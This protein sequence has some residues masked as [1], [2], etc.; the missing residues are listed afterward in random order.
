MVNRATES[1]GST[2]FPQNRQIFTFIVAIAHSCTINII[3][4]HAIVL[5]QRVRGCAAEHVAFRVLLHAS[6]SCMN[7]LGPYVY[8]HFLRQNIRKTY[9]MCMQSVPGLLPPP[10]PLIRR[11]GDETNVCDV[12]IKNPGISEDIKRHAHTAI[13]R[14]LCL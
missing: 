3:I 8:G 6:S 5:A 13:Y 4:V 10:P 14:F 12:P 1:L 9:C 11:P 7:T 2:V